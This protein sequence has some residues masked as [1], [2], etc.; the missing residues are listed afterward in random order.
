LSFDKGKGCGYFMYIV[1]EIFGL[2]I[3]YSVGILPKMKTKTY[4]PVV[5]SLLF[6]LS[7]VKHKNCFPSDPQS[8]RALVVGTRQTLGTS[9]GN[10]VEAVVGNKASRFQWKNP[11]VG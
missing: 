5:Y 9:R 7:S 11:D 2:G 8:V 1:R 10:T 3:T 6:A 4:S